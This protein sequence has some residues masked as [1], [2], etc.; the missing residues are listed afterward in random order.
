MLRVQYELNGSWV[1]VPD[2]LPTSLYSNLP[3]YAVHYAAKLARTDYSHVRVIW[4][5]TYQGQTL[6]ACT[7]WKRTG[8]YPN[9][10]PQLAMNTVDE[11]T[12]PVLLSERA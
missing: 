7:Y 4:P 8:K 10:I 5:Y 3:V 6:H 2:P 11:F 1:D 9:H 12:E